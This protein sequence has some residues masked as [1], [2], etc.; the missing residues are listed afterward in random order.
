MTSPIKGLQTTI[1]RVPDLAAAKKWYIEAFQSDPYFDE[2]FYVGFNLGGYELGLHPETEDDKIGDKRTHGVEAY[3]GVN[4]VK[5]EHERFLSLG[6]TEH[7]APMNVGGEIEVSCVLDP[8]NN[9][10]GFIYNPDFVSRQ[11]HS[12]S[13]SDA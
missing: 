3:W 11:F 12:K 9:I 6:A 13:D 1:Y 10:I 2:P 5:S 4:D 7:T 8:W